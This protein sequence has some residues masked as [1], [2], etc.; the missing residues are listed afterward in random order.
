M[1]V[2]LAADEIGLRV[3]LQV[4]SMGPFCFEDVQDIEPQKLIDPPYHS[5]GDLAILGA[6]RL[7]VESG[8]YIAGFRGA[9]EL[10]ELAICDE[11]SSECKIPE[12]YIGKFW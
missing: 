12:L 9:L 8:D 11:T 1:V 6:A 10:W 3:A 7:T 4:T 2:D 5:A